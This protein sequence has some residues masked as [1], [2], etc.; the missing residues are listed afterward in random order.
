M[1]LLA[2]FEGDIGDF[3][4]G[5]FIDFL[6]QNHSGMHIIASGAVAISDLPDPFQQALNLDNPPSY[7]Y[8]EYQQ[9]QQQGYITFTRFKIAPHVLQ[10]GEGSQWHEFNPHFVY[11][12]PVLGDDNSLDSVDDLEEVG[13]KLGLTE[14]EVS[15]IKEIA[16]KDI[17]I[18]EFISKSQFTALYK[19][20]GGDYLSALKNMLQTLL[21]THQDEA[22]LMKETM[23]I[24]CGNCPTPVISAVIQ[25]SL[26]MRIKAGNP[27]SDIEFSRFALMDYL[28]KTVKTSPEE[29]ERIEI[30]NG[31]VNAIFSKNAGNLN[32]GSLKIEH[33]S[34]YH[35]FEPISAYEAFGY[36]TIKDTHINQ[37]KE[38]LLNSETGGGSYQLNVDK[39]NQITKQYK[40]DRFGMVDGNQAVINQIDKELNNYFNENLDLFLENHPWKDLTEDQ[41]KHEI[42][43]QFEKL[44]AENPGKDNDAIKQLL[45]KNEKLKFSTLKNAPTINFSS[46]KSEY[47]Q[48]NNNVNAYN[49]QKL[50]FIAVSRRKSGF[51]HPLNTTN[52]ADNLLKI[53]N[54]KDGGI[55]LRKTILGDKEDR[56][57]R[58]RDLRAFAKDGAKGV[59]KTST[60]SLL[61]QYDKDNERFF[62][63][64]HR[65]QKALRD[66]FTQHIRDKN[67]ENNLLNNP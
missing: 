28:Q 11:H 18:K 62:S 59:D 8:I 10:G 56:K 30:I 17:R 13:N 3:H 40:K 48:G 25:H 22:A 39:I 58:M 14:T 54:D 63:F 20:L 19:N 44:Q 12:P 29:G 5:N 66:F 31:M 15:G 55:S 43:T 32:N 49:L 67:S 52:S 24:A 16:N 21:S 34:T 61:N 50:A 45:V 7:V 60:S 47:L 36:A 53:I 65:E 4:A 51:F 38:L 64:K 33:N 1:Y 42:S 27:I 46:E 6:H 41:R 37:I 35:Q 26:R 23:V 57:I 9:A 2:K